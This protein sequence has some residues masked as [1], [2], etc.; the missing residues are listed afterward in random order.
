[1]LAK[2]VVLIGDGNLSVDKSLARDET[3]V[4][5]VGTHT[6]TMSM[7]YADLKRLTNPTEAE[8]AHHL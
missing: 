7:E 3:I 6:D 5:E 2:V 1:M 8:F 4:F